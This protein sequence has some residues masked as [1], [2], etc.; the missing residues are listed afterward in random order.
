MGQKGNQKNLYSLTKKEAVTSVLCF[1]R[2]QQIGTP[3]STL[4]SVPIDWPSLTF[5][6]LQAPPA[7]YS[8]SWELVK[9]TIISLKTSFI[10]ENAE[11]ILEQK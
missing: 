6:M 8:A 4:P 3:S 2:H 9:G 5:H 10:F 7:T 11:Q 1:Y